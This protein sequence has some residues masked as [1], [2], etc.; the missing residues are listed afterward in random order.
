MKKFL[1]AFSI[2]ITICASIRAQNNTGTKTYK[3][4]IFAPLYLDNLFDIAG[5]FNYPQ[6]IPKSI[7]PGVDFIQGA[8]AAL[9]SLDFGTAHIIASFYDIKSTKTPLDL[10]IKNKK[11]DSLNLIIADVKSPE[12]KTL[13]DFALLKKIPFISATYPNDG[14]II[15]NP[16]LVIVNATLKAHCEAIY[17]YLLQ[18]HGTDKIFLCRK[19]GIQEDKIAAYFK[20]LN[21]QDG[22]P[23]LNIQTLTVD[24]IVS[25]DFLNK[26]LDSNH[27]SVIIGGSLDENFASSLAHTSSDLHTQYPITL[28]GMPN[29]SGF[30]ELTQKDGFENFPIYFTSPYFYTDLN[31]DYSSLIKS[32]YN[33]KYKSTPTDMAYKGFECTYSFI[34][35]LIQYPNDLIN[36]LNDTTYKVF[37]DYTFRP[38]FI[39]KGNVLPD[40]YE[41]K[42]LYFI[43]I[44]NGT[45]SKAW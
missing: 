6:G 42:H 13:A 35:L 20:E 4:G 18:N 37:S 29:W 36:H 9:D 24:S 1:F 31:D 22:K 30:K 43:K 19:K 15:A 45:F 25:Y 34:N 16:F 38:V 3:V 10:L 11:L 21:I 12:F 17:D 8:E 32:D 14:G 39:K 40:Y 27:L 26:K 33:I 2:L 5:N 41:N 23:L 28:I 7:Q 44:M